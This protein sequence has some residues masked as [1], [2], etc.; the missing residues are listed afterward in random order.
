M[1][2]RSFVWFDLGYRPK[3]YD[4]E[5]WYANF[6]V[7]RKT[8]DFVLNSAKNDLFPEDT[9]MQLAISAKP[10]TTCK[11]QLHCTFLHQQR[12]IQSY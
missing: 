1:H 12:S 8:V 9:V 4:D 10:T 3:D 6:R 11:L 7:T 2:L 5:L